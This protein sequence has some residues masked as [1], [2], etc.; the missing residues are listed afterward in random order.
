LDDPVGMFVRE[1]LFDS[2]TV[3]E[4]RQNNCL[5]ARDFREGCLGC[6]G[7]GPSPLFRRIKLNVREC[8]GIVVRP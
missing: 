6:Q 5:H 8:D 3:R 4:S 7:R 1:L 2:G